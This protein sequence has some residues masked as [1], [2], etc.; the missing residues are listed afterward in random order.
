MSL[1]WESD[2]FILSTQK[3]FPSRYPILPQIIQLI[4]TLTTFDPNYA[5]VASVNRR[6]IHAD[7]GEGS[8]EHKAAIWM[9]NWPS[10]WKKGIWYNIW[11]TL[12]LCLNKFELDVIL[13]W[14]CINTNLICFCDIVQCIP[15]TGFEEEIA[16]I[17]PKAQFVTV[18][19]IIFCMHVP[20]K[21]HLPL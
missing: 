13:L 14:I 7:S 3:P 5:P 16:M 4:I 17:P 12:M 19:C 1:H 10:T 2:T 8:M 18:V 9:K 21:W 20:W 6:L 15:S 11:L